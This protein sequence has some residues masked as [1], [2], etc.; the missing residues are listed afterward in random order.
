MGDLGTCTAKQ[1]V[2]PLGLQKWMG[3]TMFLNCVDCWTI[4]IA[5]I[6]A[7]S[8]ELEMP[9]GV[10]QTSIWMLFYTWKWYMFLPSV[11]A[12]DMG[13][14]WGVSFQCICQLEGCAHQKHGKLMMWWCALFALLCSAVIKYARMWHT[15]NIK[16]VTC[17]CDCSNSSEILLNATYIKGT[18]CIEFLKIAF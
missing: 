3:I 5:H 2:Y 18:I 10:M 11:L 12:V 17:R 8:C 14:W 16:N 13:I 6:I 1:N 4:L 9:H 7:A 15:K